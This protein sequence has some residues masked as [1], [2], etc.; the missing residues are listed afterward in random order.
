V[1][2][3]VADLRGPIPEAARLVIDRRG[4]R[5]KQVG[6]IYHR[7]L[8]IVGVG[9]SNDQPMV[10][11]KWT[12]AFVGEVLDFREDDPGRECDSELV[13][14]L[15][16]EIGPHGM[17]GRDG[18]WHIVAY[19]HHLD[20]LHLQCDYLA[21]KPL[22]YRTDFGGCAS[23]PAACALLGPTPMDEIY[24]SAVTKWGY[25]PEPW[26]TPYLNVR[27]VMPGEHVVLGDVGFV[28]KDIIDP[29]RPRPW[30]LKTEIEAAVRRRVQSSDVPVAC[31]LSGGLDS[32]ITYTLSRRYGTVRPY[33]VNIDGDDEER[34]LVELVAQ[35]TVQEVQF[36]KTST[37]DALGIMQEPI[38]LGSLLPQI[39]LSAAVRETVCLT[40]DGAD[41]LF[42]GY[43]RAQEYDSQWSDVFHELVCWH[44]P[45][46]DRVMM[47]NLIEVRSPF[48]A[49]RVVEAALAL[50]RDMRT[51]KKILRELF[52]DVLPEEI[53]Y[54]KKKPLKVERTNVTSYRVKLV[55]TF[56]E[57]NQ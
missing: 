26:R 7:R 16:E 54:Q 53:V 45:R 21:Q 38:D 8:P 40:G 14:D 36:R 35:D 22:Y 41:E 33:Y 18:F 55:N 2:G 27:R 5:S 51:G 24:L 44:L 25:C 1:C 29:A 6:P 10:R 9:P 28:C 39:S 30:S 13:A 34:K 3:I 56:R 20:L 46:L 49:R 37:V 11:G 57:M 42:G 47:N 17:V 48:L 31:L 19:D 23:E 12:I 52:M 32:S 50:P 4:T 15:W 43:R